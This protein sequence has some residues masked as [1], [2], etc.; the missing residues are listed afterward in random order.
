MKIKNN[1]NKA[2]YVNF[3]DGGIPKKI[4]IQAGKTADVPGIAKVSQIINLGDFDRGFFEVVKEIIVKAEKP[5]AK[6]K[7]SKK[8]ASKKKKKSEDSLDKVEKEVKD[9]T[10]NE[11]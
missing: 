10:D 8:K 1:R 9:Y 6:K 7:A 11:E 3:K 2:N 4:I 5:V